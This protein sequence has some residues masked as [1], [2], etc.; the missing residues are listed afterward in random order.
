MSSRMHRIKE[1]YEL[2]SKGPYPTREQLQ[3]RFEVSQR[4]VF[5]DIQFMKERMSLDI[6]FDHHNQVYYNKN[7][8][9]RLPTF[10][11]SEE[12]VRALKL[13][14][15]FFSRYTGSAFEQVLYSALQKISDRL[16][17]ASEVKEECEKDLPLSFKSA[18]ADS[19]P[20]KQ[21]WDLNEACLSNSSV[22]FDYY[23]PKSDALTSRKFDPYQM[24]ERTGNW[25]VM[26]YCH[27]RKTL[28]MF[29]LQ[30]IRNLEVLKEQFEKREELMPEDWLNSAFQLEVGATKFQAA[31]KFSPFAARYIREKLWHPSQ[32]ITE[33]EDGGLTLRFTGTSLE[34]VKRWVLYY[35]AEAEVLEPEELRDLLAAELDKTLEKYNRH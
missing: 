23:S 7:P 24:V 15:K 31:I 6:E 27:L 18:V 5:L 13:S 21:F 16:P 25:Y 35:G 11:L 30:R 8:K 26:G 4:T 2:M 29:A 12:E 17:D 32:E 14:T 3:D 22:H 20:L 9:K 34:E 33:N 28:R 10:D 1:M 19:L